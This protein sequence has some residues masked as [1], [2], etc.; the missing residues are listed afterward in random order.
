[1]NGQYDD[2][3]DHL[4]QQMQAMLTNYKKLVNA[5]AT[6]I[7]MDETRPLY[8]TKR[9]D[10]NNPPVPTSMQS[11]NIN[12]YDFNDIRYHQKKKMFLRELLVVDKLELYN[13]VQ[14]I[15]E[16]KVIATIGQLYNETNVL[17]PLSNEHTTATYCYSLVEPVVEHLENKDKFDEFNKPTSCLANIKELPTK[18]PD[19]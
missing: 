11:Q 6:Q 3:L 2:D 14:A 19:S 5:L 17:Q 1:Q 18:E 16:M 7:E 10:L 13:M 15:L 4:T 9:N 8:I 12:M